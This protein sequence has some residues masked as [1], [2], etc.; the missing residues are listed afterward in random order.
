MGDIL[1]WAP[2]VDH[3][4]EL[5]AGARGVA[6]QLGGQVVALALGDQASRG[7]EFAQRSADRVLT[8][9]HALLKGAVQVEPYADALLQLIAKTKPSAVLVGS[10][11]RAKDAATRVATRLE[12]GCGSDHA[13]LRVEGGRIV[14]ER[15][16]YSGNSILTERLLKDPQIIVVPSRA[17]E[18]PTADPSL[19]GS[20]EAVTLDL[21]PPK[22]KLVAAEKKPSHGVNLEDADVVV[23]VGR[24]VKRKEDIAMADQLAK[25]VGGAVGC[26]RPIAADLKWLGDEHWIGLSGHEIK[27]KA[28]IGLGVSGQIQHVAGMRGSKIVVAINKDEEAPLVKMADYAV[29]DDLYK[30]LPA[31]IKE[32]EKL[33]AGS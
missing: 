14:G 20:V 22:A 27:P 5:V 30:V 1:V 10:T 12:V 13:N 4:F 7:A 2:D 31:F 6:A 23:S 8:C 29:V 16:F 24:G 19:K 28:Y 21:R 32:V 9:D 33:R 25:A 15:A 3:A 11:I 26:T 17:Y 18:V